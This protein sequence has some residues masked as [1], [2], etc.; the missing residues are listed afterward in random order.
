M[1]D[2]DHLLAGAVHVVDEAGGR[3]PRQC[4]QHA[5]D[6]LLD[7]GFPFA[8]VFVFDVVEMARQALELLGK[9]PL[10]VIAARADQIDGFLDEHR[11]VQDH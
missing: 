4:L 3:C 9:R 2:H 1:R 5:F 11:I 8:Q 10:D 6:H 7:V